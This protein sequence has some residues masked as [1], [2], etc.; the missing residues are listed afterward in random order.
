MEHKN[1]LRMAVES[2][3]KHLIRCLMT[4]EENENNE[5][6][7]NSLTLSELEEEWK[8]Y[9]GRDEPGIG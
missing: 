2:R 3:K 4:L 8:R 1:L 6:H 7:L 5:Q 9:Q